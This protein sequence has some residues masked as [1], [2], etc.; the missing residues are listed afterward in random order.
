VSAGSL[1]PGLSLNASTGVLSGT[2]TIA[3]VTI[4]TVQVRS[5]SGTSAAQFVV[6][7]INQA[8]TI[9]NGDPPPALVGSPY[10]FGFTASGT[11]APMWQTIAGMLPPGLALDP[12]SGEVKGIPMRE[13]VYT[14]TIQASNG[15]GSPA[16]QQLILTVRIPIYLPIIVR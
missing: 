1:P 6:L 5:G 2:P 13:G 8:P 11:P 4:F 14:F 9:T 16:T 3:G 15:I 12:T 7:R 10:R